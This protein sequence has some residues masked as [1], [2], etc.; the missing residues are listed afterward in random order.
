MRFVELGATASAD[1]VAE[2]PTPLPPELARDIACRVRAAIA[3]GDVTAVMTIAAELTA[4][5]DATVRYGEELHRLANALDFEAVLRLVD[6]LDQTA[7][8][9]KESP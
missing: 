9:G 8:H 2:A 1:A 4:Q 7:S 5:S 3:V 6:A